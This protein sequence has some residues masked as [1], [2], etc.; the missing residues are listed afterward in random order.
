MGR[1]EFEVVKQNVLKRKVRRRMGLFIDATG[2]DRATRRL[3]KKIDLSRL[4]KG[5]SSGLKIEVARYYCLIPVSYTHLT[6][7]TIC[8]V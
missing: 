5:L 6:L 1:E 7:P 8:S 4:V 3:D 2:L